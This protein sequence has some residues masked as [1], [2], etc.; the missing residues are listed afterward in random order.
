MNREQEKIR[1]SNDCANLFDKVEDAFDKWHE[2]LNG[3]DTYDRVEL[4]VPP[5][6]FKLLASHFAHHFDVNDE[7]I[8]YFLNLLKTEIKEVHLDNIKHEAKCAESMVQA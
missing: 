6:L 3:Q 1:F 2:E 8:A 4:S 7:S 5:V